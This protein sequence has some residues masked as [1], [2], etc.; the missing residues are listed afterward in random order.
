MEMKLTITNLPFD[1]QQQVKTQQ[2]CRP[3]DRWTLFL[4]FKVS[5]RYSRLSENAGHLN[6][7]I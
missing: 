5:I 7:A 1:L 3:L 4:E 2:R 6:L